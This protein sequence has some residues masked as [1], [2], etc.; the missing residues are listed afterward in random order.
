M[1][2]EART[3]LIR[4]H[5][6]HALEYCERLFYLEE[7]EGLGTADEAVFAGRV[8][9]QELTQDGQRVELQ[10]S[11]E[12]LGLY[13]RVDGVRTRDGKLVVYEHKR[14]R[15][16][17][18][19]NGPNVWPS[20][21]LQ[22]GAY[23]LL[24]E[25][26][27]PGITVECRVRYHRP[28]ATVSLPVDAELRADVKSAVER[29]RLLQASTRRPPVTSDER[30]CSRC[31]LAPVCLPEEERLDSQK[32]ELPR[33]FPAD[34]QRQTV[35]LTAPG[36]RI[37]RSGDEILV[38]PLEGEGV[39]LPGKTVAALVLH[40]G[41]QISAQAV[42]M[43]VQ[44]GIGLHW[45]TA[46]GRYLGTLSGV[47]EHVHRRLRQF[48]ALNDPERC[49]ELARRLVVAKVE[50]QLRFLL[51]ASR[52]GSTSRIEIAAMVRDLRGILRHIHRSESLEELRGL[53]GAA[54]ARY[55]AALPHLLGDQV[56][57]RLR[58]DGRSRRPPRD[59]FNAILGFL[60]QLVHRE[61]M[62]AILSVGLDPAFGFYHQ[63]RTTAGPLSLD[64]M[65]LFR[66]PLADMPLISS[67]N[68]RAWDPNDDFI[69][70]A[71]HVWLSSQGRAKA[72]D[73]FERRK[74]ETWK[75]NKLRYSLS[76]A[77]LIEL[78]VRLL[79]KEWTGRQ[80]LFATFRLR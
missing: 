36:T 15:P 70:R 56:D 9:H 20:D 8:L 21:R 76:Y 6:L 37:G 64:L 41:V 4:V 11:S 38:T 60:Y 22:A 55:F 18:G 31:S 50:G 73:L 24:A 5:A 3:D 75:H 13:G 49:V 39:R 7:V 47:A 12:A 74:H 79:E 2:P 32:S 1:D 48:E 66:V 68:R 25:E 46:G 52:G 43:C 78:E 19:P 42:G 71:G 57:E 44:N 69:E 45:F 58:F 51:R 63:P 72:I 14:G 16:A 77:R 17:P 34:D 29:A 67:L 26:A 59:P 28:P 23:A 33:L 30:R 10:L 54:A 65:E 53:E 27:N 35:H 40:G 61:V 62:A 80:G